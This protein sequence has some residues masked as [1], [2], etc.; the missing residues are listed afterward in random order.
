MGGC[1]FRKLEDG[2]VE[3][4]VDYGIARVRDSWLEALGDP[5]MLVTGAGGFI[6]RY[7][8]DL[9]TGLGYRVFATDVGP[10]PRYLARPKF[11]A[12]KYA[13]ADLR[14]EN[15][16]V[17]L[18]RRVKPAVVFHIGAI[19]DFSAASELLREVNVAGTE[20]VSEAARDGGAKRLV[21]WSTGSIY[22]ASDEPA[23]ESA[24]K[25]PADPYARSKLEGELAAFAYHEPGRFEVYSVRPAMVSGVLSRY[26]SGLVTRLIYEGYLVGA[27]QRRG[28]MTAVVN[29]RDV[30]TCGYLLA[31][32]D[33][34]LPRDSS[35][36]TAFNATAD[37]MEM[38][39]MMR[40]LGEKVPRRHILGVRT[41]LAEIIGFGFQERFRL[42]DRLVD[43]IAQASRLAT[44]ALNRV[45]PS[46]LFPK[47]PPETIPYI[48]Q[49]HPMSNAKAK[50]L[51]GWRPDPADADFDETLRYYEETGWSGFERGGT[52]PGT[53]CAKHPSGRPGKRFL[54]PFPTRVREFEEVE[55]LVR[56]LRSE[57]DPYVEPS[58]KVPSLG[59][60]IDTWS[61]RA[62][63]RS[64]ESYLLEKAYRGG[65]ADLL[66]GTIPRLAGHAASDVLLY[67]KAAY[68]TRYGRGGLP[69]SEV[70]ALAKRALGLDRDQV[71]TWIVA[72]N[73]ARV[74]DEL[75]RA[76][77]TLRRLAPLLPEGT[78]GLLIETEYGDV[79]VEYR[80][81]PPEDGIS[82]PR[83]DVDTIARHLPLRERTEQLRKIRGMKLALGIRCRD[84]VEMFS[85]RATAKELEGAFVCSPADVL[86]R[87]TGKIESSGW[88][89]LIFEGEKGRY[90]VGVELT[91]AASLLSPARLR[92]YRKARD[93][94][95][96][97]EFVKGIDEASSGR[98]KVKVYPLA[99][100]RGLLAEAMAPGIVTRLLGR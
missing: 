1:S 74:I 59:F 65:L 46:K 67:L 87:L 4:L 2:Q 20:R 49:P 68:L 72:A 98:E 61:L 10:R 84:L 27:P 31:A 14:E 99:D 58:V 36:D 21:Y 26:G 39:T 85:G 22:S 63:V 82:F 79:A 55:G 34:D 18:V 19:F 100:F 52:V 37:P 38:D 78:Y 73:L 53:V 77:G 93:L 8:V 29:A 9:L 96:L 91:G 54:A 69:E 90:K 75:E 70:P 95:G 30:A 12:V 66:V 92:A 24:P 81:S 42:P 33:L 43:L 17:A 83:N 23:T 35:D 6:G 16:V 7:M 41:K 15:E 51:L 64:A 25:S 88:T 97:T 32:T 40:I 60:E 71:V 13:A 76:G 44:G 89:L 45:R 57:T 11:K 50:D 62:L 56:A 5:V 94:L 48:T 80:R 47:I 28:M 86:S 3:L